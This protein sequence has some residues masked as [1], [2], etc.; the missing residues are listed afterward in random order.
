MPDFHLAV[1]M[2]VSSF[3]VIAIVL[4]RKI[5]Q[6]QLSSKWQY[7]LWF[8]LLPALTL[9]FLPANLLNVGSSFVWNRNQNNNLS[10]ANPST[11]NLITENGRNW[12]HDF[13]ISVNRFD[14]TWLNQILTF[15]WIAGIL[16]MVALNL[17]AWLKLNQVKKSSRTITNQEVLTIFDKCRQ[18]LHIS[19]KTVLADSPLVN[20]PMTFGIFKTYII[21]P[22][23]AK[24]WLSDDELT[25]IFLHELHHVKYKDIATNYLIVLFQML[26]W[27]NPLIWMAFRKMRLDREIA[28]DSAVLKTLDQDNYAA[29]GDTIIKFAEKSISASRFAM[30]NQLA[31]SKQHL[32]ER[33]VRIAAFKTESRR[34]KIKSILVFSLLATVVV[35][36]IPVVSAMSYGEDRINFENKQTV[37]EDL[38]D[39]FDGYDGSF[40]L[41]DLQKAQYHIYNKEKSVLRVSPNSTY[42]IYDAL[43]ALDSGVITPGQTSLEWDGTPY[44]YK[45]WNQN[46]NLSTAMENSVSWYFQELDKK[47]QRHH[48]QAYVQKIQYGNQNLSGGLET[49]WLESS[50][51]ISPIEQV[52]TLKDFYT[53][54]FKFKEKHVQFVKKSIKLESKDHAALYGKTGT[55]TVN[56]KNVNGWFIGYVETKNNTYFFATNIENNHHANGSIAAEITKSILK[57]K[58]IY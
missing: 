23:D 30:V 15:A 11:E 43:F 27:Y 45:A 47:I 24:A 31:S 36:Q 38:N 13:S 51:K 19:Q 14:V 1:C 20:S 34:L 33:I 52:Q 21:L 25:Y 4:I 55:G 9:P 3:V 28:C 39:F 26:Y 53:N 5:F 54:Q 32:K 44:P 7:N 41:Y 16:V 46:Q 50:L 6:N 58:D 10:P 40:V 57:D 42:K 17:H 37:Y 12:A 18:R 2:F 56:G 35:C 22:C 29:Y 8:I 49:Y 48:I